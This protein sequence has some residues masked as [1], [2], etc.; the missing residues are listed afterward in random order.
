MIGWWANP[1]AHFEDLSCAKAW[2]PVAWQIISGISISSSFVCTVYSSLCRSSLSF[3]EQ[4]FVTRMKY[5][6]LKKTCCHLFKWNTLPLIFRKDLESIISEGEEYSWKEQ[7]F[8]DSEDQ[9][10]KGKTQNIWIIGSK[11]LHQ[12]ILCN[13]ISHVKQTNRCI[14]QKKFKRN[15]WSAVSGAAGAQISL[16][17]APDRDSGD[18]FWAL[19]L[20]QCIF[21]F[22]HKK[23]YPNA[24]W[25]WN[26]YLH[27]P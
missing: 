9:F 11:K 23:N 4:N 22:H 13:F 5:V 17:E 7:F 21:F 19:S 26:I 6:E 14:F 25:D 24:L 8:S 18:K 16:W 10:Y 27:L 3:Q 2:P 20:I 12:K 15:R 1:L